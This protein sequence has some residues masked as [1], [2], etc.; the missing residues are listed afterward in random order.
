MSQT[1]QRANP[2]RRQRLRQHRLLMRIQDKL[3][4]ANAKYANFFETVQIG[5]MIYIF[6]KRPSIQFI[7]KTL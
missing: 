1:Y 4:K 5:D 2:S 3:A 6:H 7:D